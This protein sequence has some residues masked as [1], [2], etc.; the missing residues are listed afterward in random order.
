MR[1]VEFTQRKPPGG[2]HWLDGK[3]NVF[4][5]Q[6][7]PELLQSIRDFRM[8]NGIDVG[9]PEHD[10][11]L[12]YVKIAPW[13]VEGGPELRDQSTY[14]QVT[15]NWVNGLWGHRLPFIPHPDAIERTKAC[16]GCLHHIP[17]K[18]SPEGRELRRRAMLVSEGQ[19]PAWLGMCAKHGWHC[20]VAVR[21]KEAECEFWKQ[22]DTTPA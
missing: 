6:T 11:C 4:R 10:V 9:S 21:M 22:D 14:E 2:H 3:G 8:T 7:L 12:Y 15:L 16:E 1:L 19:M 5:A 18:D 13:W 17:V 20:A